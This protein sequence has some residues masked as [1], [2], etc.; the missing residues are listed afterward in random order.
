MLGAIAGDVIGS[1]YEAAPIGARL[2]DR[3]AW[4]NGRGSGQVLTLA[5]KRRS[6]LEQLAVLGGID[7]HLVELGEHRL[8]HVREQDALRTQF[9]NAGL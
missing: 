7:R 4:S 3:C 5:G 2:D 6:K 1:I 9:A 8:A